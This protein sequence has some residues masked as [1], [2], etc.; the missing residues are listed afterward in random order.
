[1]L[2]INRD[3]FSE[4]ESA[5]GRLKGNDTDAAALRTIGDALS[6]LTKRAIVVNAIRPESQNQTCFVMSVYPDESTMD[7]LVQ[8]IISEEKDAV[9]GKIWN[10]SAKWNIEIDTRILTN[11]VGMT[12]KELTALILHEIGHIMY[13]N[14]I[15]MKIAKIMRF[16]YAKSA[17]TV[18]QL[19]QDKFFGRVLLLPII[20][21]CNADRHATS[22]KDEVK[23]DKYA[24]N[25]GFGNDL[26][27][28]MDKVILYAG[29]DTH[30]DVEMEQLMGFSIDSITQLQKRQNIAVHNN[31]KKLIVS[32]PSRVA[33]KLVG[34]MAKI[35]G[36][37]QNV[38]TEAAKADMLERH[39]RESEEKYDLSMTRCVTEGV[40]NR[41]HKMKRIDPADIDY[42]GLELENIK[43]N[44]DK[45]M[46]VS[47]IYNKM[48]TIDYYIALIDSKNPKYQIPHSRESL[49]QMRDTLNDYRLKA[50]NKKLPEI[51]YGIQIQYPKGY[52]G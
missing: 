35:Y 26:I 41:V 7:L 38:A 12:E 27:S 28:A 18:K 5:F 21:A 24:I 23:A 25:A 44:D 1:M 51:S 8:A 22:I 30:P 37:S 33:K 13:S 17:S 14:S 29:S 52:E 34:D 4:I 31:L 50:I 46:V 40:F 6:A 20:N 48:D 15:P 3:K 19:S 49:V 10:G 42:I 11:E 36:K 32:T 45:M 9:L 2:Y 43:S 16:Q 47:Y 39:L